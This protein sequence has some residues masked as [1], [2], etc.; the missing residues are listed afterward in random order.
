MSYVDW[1]EPGGTEVHPISGSL[2]AR[3]MYCLF[4]IQDMNLHA[5]SLRGEVSGMARDQEY[6]QPD[7]GV[8]TT[9]AGAY[10]ICPATVDSAGSSTGPAADVASHHMAP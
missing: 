9:G 1:R 4:V 6:S 8:A 10:P 7:A 2:P 3:S 5:A